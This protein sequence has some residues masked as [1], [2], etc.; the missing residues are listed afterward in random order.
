VQLQSQ[1]S[2][3]AVERASWSRRRGG[4]LQSSAIRIIEVMDASATN[5]RSSLAETSGVM[6]R[7]LEAGWEQAGG[8]LV[9]KSAKG[10]SGRL[11]LHGGAVPLGVEA[12]GVEAPFRFRSR[13]DALRSFGRSQTTGA[14]AN[15]AGIVI[16]AVTEFWAART[17]C[18]PS[19]PLRNAP[20]RSGGSSRRGSDGRRHVD[21]AVVRLPAS[22]P[23]ARRHRGGGKHRFSVVSDF[24]CM[25]AT[26]LGTC[27]T[28]IH[29]LS[30]VTFKTDDFTNDSEITC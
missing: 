9:S 15:S 12:R 21:V 6:T 19:S 30:F 28:H 24:M 4:E 7:L 25:W 13:K 5:G 1:V 10:T 20:L 8:F 16:A 23:R 26:G 11:R 18:R 27:L 2:I 29:Q 17:G 22:S 14:A 3:A